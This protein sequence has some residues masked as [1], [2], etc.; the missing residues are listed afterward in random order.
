MKVVKMGS[1]PLYTATCGCCG[2]ELEAGKAE[3]EER[4]LLGLFGFV[5]KYS[6]A[7]CT[8]CG[9]EI[10]TWKRKEVSNESNS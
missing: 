9:T 5:A 4:V 8:V 3:L 7:K 10:S 1:I 2:T 6:A